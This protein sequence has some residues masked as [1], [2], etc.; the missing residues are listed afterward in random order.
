MEPR[1]P[2]RNPGRPN[3]TPRVRARFG[4][5][6][7]STRRILS[8]PEAGQQVDYSSSRSA[9]KLVLQQGAD[10]HRH[11]KIVI[12]EKGAKTRL[13]IAR[14]YQPQLINEKSGPC[15]QPRVVP[16]SHVDHVPHQV[17]GK[18]RHEL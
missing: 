7:Y 11:P 18:Q 1:A 6:E 2:E 5:P 17:Q 16:V 9:G 3:A 13:A 12:V 14:A 8:Q 4:A 10:E 15:A